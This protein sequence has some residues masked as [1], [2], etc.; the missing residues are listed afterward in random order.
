M[1]ENAKLVRI[2]AYIF[3]RQMDFFQNLKKSKQIN[4]SEALRRAIDRYIAEGAEEEMDY[5]DEE[6]N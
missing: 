4:H 2:N 1:P 6:D 5:D 3:K